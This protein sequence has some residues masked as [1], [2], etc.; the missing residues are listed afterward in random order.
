MFKFKDIN[1][2]L[3]VINAKEV[4]SAILVTDVTTKKF[5]NVCIHFRHC[6]SSVTFKFK[7]EDDARRVIELIYNNY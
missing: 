4:L 3:M 7:N 5:S 6:N 1:D 2:N